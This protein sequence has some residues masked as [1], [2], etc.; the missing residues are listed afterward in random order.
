MPFSLAPYPIPVPLVLIVHNS[1]MAFRFRQELRNSVE[2]PSVMEDLLG[3]SLMESANV[4]LVK[5]S[6]IWKVPK[7]V[8]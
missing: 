8:Q 6:A 5:V 2:I 7:R 4:G 3:E 1:G